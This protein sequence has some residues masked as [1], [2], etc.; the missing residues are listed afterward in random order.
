MSKVVVEKNID[1]PI[2]E[3]FNAVADVREF[4]KVVGNITNIEFL[5]EQ[6]TGVG[7]KFR[8]TRVMNGKEATTELEVTEYD[9]N[10]K[11]RLVADAGGTI[12]DTIFETKPSNNATLLTMNMEARPYKLISKVMNLFIMGFV[13]KAIEKDM[14]AV[15]HFCESYD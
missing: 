7:T 9:E 6:K 2:P 11:V 3:V 15:K 13:T 5:T 10:E 14:D 8:E 1:A 4:S 12:W